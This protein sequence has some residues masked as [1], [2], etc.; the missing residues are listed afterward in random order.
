MRKKNVTIPDGDT[1][2]IA[3]LSHE[4]LTQWAEERQE[5][6]GEDYKA[7]LKEFATWSAVA[8]KKWLKKIQTVGFEFICTSLNRAAGN[9]DWTPERIYKELD[10]VEYNFLNTEI[11]TFNGLRSNKDAVGEPDE[12]KRLGE[13]PS[14]PLSD[15]SAK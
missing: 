14:A 12:I 6:F 5:L 7:K 2:T 3:S 4:L 11:L 15:S 9:K 10:P 1:Y 13:A 8:Q